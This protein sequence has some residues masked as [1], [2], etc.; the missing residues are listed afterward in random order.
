[1]NTVRITRDAVYWTLAGD[2]DAGKLSCFEWKV[3]YLDGR[4]KVFVTAQNGEWEFTIT[5]GRCDEGAE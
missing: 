4:K 5:R 1:M 2:L 3:P